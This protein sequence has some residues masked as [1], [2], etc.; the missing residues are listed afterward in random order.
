MGIHFN[1]KAA[2]NARIF[3]FFVPDNLT[4]PDFLSS[5]TSNKVFIAETNCFGRPSRAADVDAIFLFDC[6]VSCLFSTFIGAIGRW[7][8]SSLVRNHDIRLET[9]KHCEW[10]W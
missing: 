2:G 9:V 7:A 4:N 8:S 5:M 3:I 6:E 1:V 10:V